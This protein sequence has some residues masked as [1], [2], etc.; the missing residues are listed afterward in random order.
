MRS[1][2]VL[3]DGAAG[4]CLWAKAREQVDVWRYNIEQ[5][6]IVEELCREYIDAGSQIVQANTFSANRISLKKSPYTVGQIVSA[7]VTIAK[8]AA[9]G[10]ARVGVSVGPL[11]E[12]LEPYGDLT[13]EEAAD[14]YAEQIR[15]GVE[16]GAD[17]IQIETFMDI[18]LGRI[19]VREACSHGLPVLVSFSFDPNGRTM[20]GNSVKDIV[21]GLA[22]FPVEAIG[23]NCSLGPEKA[24][25]V[26]AQF[27][28]L[29]DKP[30]VFKPNA[31]LPSED[32]A[33]FD[34][35]TFVTDALPALAYNVKYIGGCCGSS[36]QYIALLKQGIDKLR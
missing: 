23:L 16:A 14:I 9:G 4:T 7:G 26:I 17:L 2:I 8:R 32:G 20:M 35:Q 33:E 34:A 27:A 3:L 11:S 18:E 24:V 21:D 22:E 36:P 12:L 19:A 25:P 28:E 29:T 10:R 30:L 1:D 6:E 5:P 13:E 31:G 15:A